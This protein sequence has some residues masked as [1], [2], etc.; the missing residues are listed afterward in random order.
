MACSDRSNSA[1]IRVC[2]T[3][4]MEGCFSTRKDWLRGCIAA[5]L[6]IQRPAHASFTRS[7]ADF[8]S[9]FV[10]H[11]DE[12]RACRPRNTSHLLHNT[13]HRPRRGC[14]STRN[15]STTG[16]GGCSGRQTLRGSATSTRLTAWPTTAPTSGTRRYGGCR[17]HRRG[18][19]LVRSFAG[20]LA[21]GPAGT[22]AAE[23]VVQLKLFCSFF[24]WSPLTLSA[25]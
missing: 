5:V 7:F 23:S 15:T 25:G 10:R 19:E 12:R 16:L 22:A 2:T 8:C 6:C 11:I 1:F 9:A 21:R 17:Q 13:P 20:W 24:L 3:T 4:W 18:N 14:R